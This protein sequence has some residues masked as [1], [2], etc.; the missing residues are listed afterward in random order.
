MILEQFAI[1]T[2]STLTAAAIAAL[3]GFLFRNKIRK[4]LRGLDLL[5]SSH[6]PAI[7]FVD[8][9]YITDLNYNKNV[10]FLIKNCGSVDISN[11]KLFSCSVENAGNPTSLSIVNLPYER[12]FTTISQNDGEVMQ[13]AVGAEYFKQD[14]FY[15]NSR[16]FIEMASEDGSC[17]RATIIRAADDNSIDFGE[18]GFF[19]DHIGRVR[20]PLPP[21]KIET[22]NTAKIKRLVKRYSIDLSVG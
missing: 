19:V 8:M 16:L 1:S 18:G 5:A 9:Q 13:L 11:I 4:A 20:K 10:H 2:S 12:Q 14:S 6:A 17:F 15:P 3:I 21:W 22:G 7:E